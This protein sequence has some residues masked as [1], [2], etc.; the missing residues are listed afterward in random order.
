MSGMRKAIADNMVKSFYEAPHA[1][2]VSEMDITSILSLIAKNKEAFLQTHGVKLTITSFVAKAIAQALQEFP[3]INSS[4]EKDTIVLKKY[5][6]LGV[7]VS[8][9]Q[10]LL[11]PVIKN[12]QKNGYHRYC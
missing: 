7:A 1:T 5:V 3:L 6:N 4:L 12:C 10:G 2:L 9:D 11:V 8:V